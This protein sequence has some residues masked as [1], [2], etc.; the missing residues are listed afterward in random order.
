MLEKQQSFIPNYKNH[1]NIS[2]S[3]TTISLT[4]HQIT[5][6]HDFF[7]VNINGIDGNHKPK[8]EA[9]HKHFRVNFFMKPT[10]K[11]SH[12]CRKYRR[13]VES[14]ATLLCIFERKIQ[15]RRQI[16]TIWYLA[17]VRVEKSLH[18]N[19]WFLCC[20]YVRFHKNSSPSGSK[21]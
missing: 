19:K 17:V 8:A 20:F 13:E 6:S 21:W 1:K 2:L 14:L 4:K 15:I 7:W 16:D 18:S 10:T 5:V 12:I 11:L 3:T 9:N